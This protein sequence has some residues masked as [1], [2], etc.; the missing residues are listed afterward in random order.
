MIWVLR[1]VSGLCLFWPIRKVRFS[2]N[3]PDWFVKDDS[4][5]PWYI[6]G[7]G[8][9]PHDYWACLDFSRKD[10]HDHIKN[11]FETFYE[12]AFGISSLTAAVF[13]P[14]PELEAQKMQTGVSCLR[15]GLKV[16]REAVKDSIVLGCAISVFALNRPC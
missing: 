1:P 11:V 15:T 9:E 2:K 8:V 12:W 14:L 3:T 5:N 7:W 6:R 13:L 16:L 4:G 10:V